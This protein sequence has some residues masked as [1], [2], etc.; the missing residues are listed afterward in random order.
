MVSFFVFMFLIPI[1]DF[2]VKFWIQNN[3]PENVIVQTF[4]PF[5]S[6]TYVKNFG[7]ALSLFWGGRYFFVISSVFGIFLL[8]YFVFIKK[9]RNK[10]FLLASS[11]IIGGGISNLMDRIFLGYVVDYLKL[12]FFGPIC[13]ISDYFITF[14]VI[15]FAFYFLTKKD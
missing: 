11:F 7:A 12:S 3:I 13:N 6:I 10:L 14:G 15:I 2:L 1:T 5:L 8:L 9:I 4:L